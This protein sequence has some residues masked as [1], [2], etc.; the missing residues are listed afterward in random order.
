MDA[1]RDVGR[2]RAAFLA[3]CG[4]LALAAF[5]LLTASTL[6]G[7]DRG[8]YGGSW[9]GRW[10]YVV[11][12][13]LGVLTVLVRAPGLA[14]AWA[15]AMTVATLGRALSLWLKGSPDVVSRAAEIRGGFGWLLFWFLGAIAIVT[16]EA[17]STIR[18]ALDS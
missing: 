16:M 9:D 11:A 3:S 15:M 10:V 7:A 4:T 6:E 1:R 2:R 13:V 8:L 5:F 18:R 12:G 17:S 14:L